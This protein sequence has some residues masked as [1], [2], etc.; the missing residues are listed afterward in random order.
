MRVTVYLGSRCNLNCRYCH[1]EAEANEPMVSEKF[2]DELSM[3]E[4]LTIKFMGGEPTLYMDTIKKFVDRLPHAKFAVTTNG[5][6]LDDHIDYFRKHK[7]FICLSYDGAGSEMRGFDPFTKLINYPWLHV[8]CV[9]YH[10]NTDLGK[11]YNDFAQ[12]EDVVGRNLAFYPHIMHVTNSINDEYK[13]T[14]ADFDSII[15]QTQMIM[16][17]FLQHYLATGKV[18][19]RYYPYYS[20]LA[21]R[22][23]AN[24]E[25]GETF[26]VN[27]NV[28][29]MDVSGNSF[30]CQYIRDE[31]LTDELSDMQKLIDRKSPACRTCE[32][33]GMCGGACIKSAEHHLECY[34]YKKLF[35]WFMSWYEANKEVLDSIKL[36]RPYADAPHKFKFADLYV[37]ADAYH[38][39]DV[40]DYSLQ[41]NDETAVVLFSLNGI[42]YKAE[43]KLDKIPDG[44]C[45]SVFFSKETHEVKVVYDSKQ[46]F[47]KLELTPEEY[48]ATFKMPCVLQ[49]NALGDGR[50]FTKCFP[51]PR[52]KKIDLTYKGENIGYRQ[53][54]MNNVHEIER[55]YTFSVFP[56]ELEIKNGIITTLWRVMISPDYPKKLYLNY[57]GH[58]KRIR[59]GLAKVSFPYKEGE[60]FYWGDEGTSYKGRSFSIEEE[61]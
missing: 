18:L 40:D 4:D 8:S 37:Y 3:M 56:H 55:R 21:E 28:L 57:N 47:Q 38:M 52:Q 32:V 48:S 31:K 5:V 30:S 19:R 26:C 49:M 23:L 35:G 2:L 42:G 15:E 24:Y 41:L 13:L 59:E 6:L 34:Y 11:I 7:F 14:K 33:Y 25:Y 53:A 22:R 27:K 50:Y 17:E 43:V 60:K 1:R 16:V 61:V 45:S 54:S 9:L 29:K 39:Q 20:H 46:F 12:K 51:S 10:G 36:P 58:S 44:E